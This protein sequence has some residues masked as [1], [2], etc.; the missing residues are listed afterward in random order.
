M[1]PF[2]YNKGFSFH[3]ED[4]TENDIDEI[5][6]SLKSELDCTVKSNKISFSGFKAAFKRFKWLSA[7]EIS[8]IKENSSIL[9]V[10][11]E[12]DFYLMGIIL[13][14]LIVGLIIGQSEG[15]GFE[16]VEIALIL[17]LFFIMYGVAV[18]TYISTI[19]FTVRTILNRKITAA[20]KEIK[21]K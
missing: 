15:I 16:S 11:L 17:L 5:I 7:G 13:I 21:S 6:E 2:T 18:Q 4:L 8:F 19:Q 20:T 9:K 12:L 3:S 14:F 1:F 10:N